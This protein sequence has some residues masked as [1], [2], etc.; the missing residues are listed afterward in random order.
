MKKTVFLTVLLWIT[1]MANSQVPFTK[2]INLTGWLQASDVAKI[3]FT[4]Y[5]EKDFRQIKSLGCD[6]IRLPF[7][8]H[9]MTKGSPDYVIN[10]MFLSYL[11]SAICWAERNNI[12][13][14]LDNHSFDPRKNTTADVEQILLKVWPQLA[15]RY[16]NKSDFII[17]EVLNEPHGI[18]D[19]T[20]NQIQLK[21]IEA[22]RTKDTR[23]YIVIGPASW[24]SYLNLD[25][26]PVYTDPRLI[27]TFHFYEPFSF[28]HQGAGWNTPDM[29]SLKGVPYPYN[30]DRMPLCPENLTNTWMEDALKKYPQQGNAGYIKSQLDIVINFMKTRNIN[31]F[32]GE[33]GA[34]MFNCDNADRVQLYADTKN[35]LE[36]NGIA[37][38]SWDYRGSFG[39]FNKGS[40]ESFPADLNLPLIKALGFNT[41]SPH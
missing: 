6:V 22:I 26:M 28:T 36:T 24:N 32:C 11:D 3:K 13:L 31:I 37:W 30:E 27:Y 40:K 5:S 34:L 16:Q 14:I 18:D 7:N 10:P 20:W 38:T 35:Y 15:E 29:R 23:H 8:L 21:A 41:P 2:G 9:G 17:Y 33:F 39:L 4:S 25:K 1:F 12:F 19:S